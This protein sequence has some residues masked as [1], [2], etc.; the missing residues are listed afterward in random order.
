MWLRRIRGAEEER[1]RLRKLERSNSLRGRKQALNETL[2]RRMEIAALRSARH[3]I[4][5]LDRNPVRRPGQ[6][7]VDDFRRTAGGSLAAPHMVLS[8]DNP[9]RSGSQ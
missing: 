1:Q 8:A 3:D 9:F 4:Q 7:S 5:R 2:E 6:G